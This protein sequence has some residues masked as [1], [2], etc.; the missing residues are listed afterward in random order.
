MWKGKMNT[1]DIIQSTGEYLTQIISQECNIPLQKLRDIQKCI[2]IPTKTG[3]ANYQQKYRSEIK[4]QNKEMTYKEIS[5]LLKKQW[6]DLS[7]QEQDSYKSTPIFDKEKYTKLQADTIVPI[8][9][10]NT[11]SIYVN[12][13]TPPSTRESARRIQRSSAPEPHNTPS[14]CESVHTS[15]EPITPPEH[16]SVTPDTVSTGEP[17]HTTPEPITPPEHVSITPDTVSTGSPVHTTPEPTRSPPA[18]ISDDIVTTP[19]CKPEPT[20]PPNSKKKYKQS[21][22]LKKNKNK[23]KIKITKVCAQARK[24]SYQSLSDEMIVRLIKVRQLE[25]PK[26]ADIKQMIRILEQNDNAQIDEFDT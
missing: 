5:E 16:T 3:W 10:E 15:P 19:P 2:T 8:Q 14:T 23:S 13:S 9:K 25:H 24:T 12:P 18:F 21:S 26:S 4:K 20:S 22:R 7:T 6:N 17:V 1:S 11:Q